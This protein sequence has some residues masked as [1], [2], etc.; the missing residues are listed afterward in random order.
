M[1]LVLVIFLAMALQDV[2]ST[3][4]SEL[5]EQHRPWQAGMADGFVDVG[6][7][8][9]VGIGGGGGAIL[10]Y[11]LSLETIGILAAPWA[12]SVIG[13]RIGY[14]LTNRAKDPER[15]KTL[16]AITDYLAAAICTLPQKSYIIFALKYLETL[17]IADISRVLGI[18]ESRISQLHVKAIIELR[19]ALL[20][21]NG[22]C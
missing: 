12:A 22:K 20:A 21:A 1:L 14:A 10:R 16:N 13:A 19:Q 15:N 2:F 9:S 4:K 18:T 7:A 5:L 3:M 8:L 17:S 11:G 6:A